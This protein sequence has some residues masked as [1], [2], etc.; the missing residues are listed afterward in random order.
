[1]R[2]GK[3]RRLARGRENSTLES[4]S[5]SVESGKSRRSCDLSEPDERTRAEEK[6]RLSHYVASKQKFLA[7]LRKQNDGV[8]NR[9]PEERMKSLIEKS[10]RLANF[11]LA[12][13]SLV[14]KVRPKE[15]GSSSKPNM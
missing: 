12:K 10:E 9:P 8:K 2:A 14:K 11:L 6:V 1:M 3:S 4:G 5:V 7:E 13:H 15:Q